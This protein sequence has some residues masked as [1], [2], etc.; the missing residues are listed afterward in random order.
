MKNALFIVNPIAGKGRP[1]RLINTIHKYINKNLFNYEVVITRTT[2][3]ATEI[4][5]NAKDSFE[6][7]IAVGGDGTVN[8]VFNGFEIGRA[9]V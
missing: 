6:L 8:E 5:K 9:H 1:E 7:I 3:H 4:A 2:G